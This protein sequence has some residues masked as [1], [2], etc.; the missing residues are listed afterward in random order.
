MYQ[1]VEATLLPRKHGST[2]TSV[3]IGPMLMSTLYSDFVEG[4][5][6]LTNPSM[7]G[8]LYVAL[9][10]IRTSNLPYYNVT[11]NAW[12]GTLG[13]LAL[14]GTYHNPEFTVKYA[15]FS[16]AWQSGFTL[17]KVHPIF[18]D[19]QVNTTELTDLYATKPN[20]PNVPQKYVVSIVNGLMHLS[21]PF[22][23]G[24]KIKDGAKTVDISGDNRVGFLSF[25]KIAEVQQFGITPDMIY[26][27]PNSN[28]DLQYGVYLDLNMDL[29]DKTL[30]FSFGGYLYANYSTFKIISREQG[31]V[32]VYPYRLEIAKRILDSKD[33]IDLSSLQLSTNPNSP[34]SISLTECTTPEVISRYITLPQ[35]FA[36]VID[37]PNVVGNRI[38]LGQTTQPGHYESATLPKHLLMDSVGKTPVY[39][40]KFAKRCWI[41]KTPYIG[42]K[43][44]IYTTT[45][46]NELDVINHVTVTYGNT[47]DEC[48]MFEVKAID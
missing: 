23:T 25:Y 45:P 10:D 34:E 43:E 12:L 31:I 11:F 40:R 27:A 6:T 48:T 41:L 35:S 24:I 47:Q 36:I 39:W 29:T 18:D 13:N 30:M 44:Y 19:V 9:S 21:V 22:K 4:I 33:L 38:P 42:R 28:G 3:N 37:H 15:N 2:W 7:S 32:I 1:F 17:Q 46:L 26:A 20:V 16:N 5:I 14:P 8:E